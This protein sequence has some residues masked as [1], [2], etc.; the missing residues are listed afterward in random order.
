MSL[1]DKLLGRDVPDVSNFPRV[2]YTQGGKLFGTDGKPVVEGIEDRILGG[3]QKENGVIV[4]PDLI[5]SRSKTEGDVLTQNKQLVQD[6]GE[7]PYIYLDSLGKPSFGIGSLLASHKQ[8]LLDAGFTEEDLSAHVQKL[9]EAKK[10]GKLP[11]MAIN[12]PEEYQLKIPRDVY[13]KTFQQGLDDA[14]K[15]YNQYIEGI[16]FIPQEAI[17][18]IKNLA[19]QL[20]PRLYKFV[21]FKKA[22]QNKDY[23]K[24]A[25]ELIKS[26]LY[27]QAPDRT[28]RRADEIRKLA[29]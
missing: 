7:I 17:P 9:Q 28:Q 27:E 16:D 26:K 1:L 22:L 13:S 11:S 23:N 2:G 24:A 4:L 21:E 5:I 10:A 6:E 3:G 25:D 18:V 15:V 20:G 14:D 8:A 19:Y 29:E 12:Y